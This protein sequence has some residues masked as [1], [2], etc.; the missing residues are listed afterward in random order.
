MSLGAKWRSSIDY[1]GEK[2]APGMKDIILLWD[3]G[4]QGSSQEGNSGIERGMLFREVSSGRQSLPDRRNS[5]RLGGGMGCTHLGISMSTGGPGLDREW[6]PGE[7]D[8]SQFIWGLECRER[9]LNA[10][11][12]SGIYLRDKGK[13]SRAWELQM[14]LRELCFW[15]KFCSEAAHPPCSGVWDPA[16]QPG[17]CSKLRQQMLGM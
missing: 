14:V 4:C 1:N 15:K 7:G 3:G 2:N 13:P 17:V 12:G 10:V 16:A 5:L 11:K 6:K 9:L 8:R